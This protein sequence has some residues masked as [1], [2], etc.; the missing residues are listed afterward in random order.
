MRGI[1]LQPVHHNFCSPHMM[2]MFKNSVPI[3]N[4]KKL[5]EH[6]NT[7]GQIS[8]SRFLKLLQPVSAG[9]ESHG[10]SV[11]E[12]GIWGLHVSHK[13]PHGRA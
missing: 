7:H 4:N 2:R 11:C 1:V 12:D 8:G 6:G 5:P 10:P 9:A 3:L 13:P